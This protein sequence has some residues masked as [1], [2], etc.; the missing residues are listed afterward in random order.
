M[1]KQ[2]RQRV[3]VF[4]GHPIKET[5]AVCEDL[6]KRLKRNNVA[7]D[8]INFANPENVPKLE[9]L[10]NAC[11]NSTNSHFMDVPLGVSMITDLLFTSPILG[12]DE[13]GITGA[14]PGA[15]GQF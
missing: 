5:I 8:V 1:N 10:V 9:A 4:V 14:N 13:A 6:G 15:G 12:G 3:I 7:I 11:N 2:Q